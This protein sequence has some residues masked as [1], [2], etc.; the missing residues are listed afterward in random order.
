MSH[1]TFLNWSTGKDSA[2]ALYRLQQDPT[3]RVEKLLTTLN[4][5]DS[6]VSMHGIRKELLLKQVQRIGLPVSILELQKGISLPDY[7]MAL[8]NKLLAL[9]DQG[10]THSAFGDIFL[11]DLKQYREAKLATIAFKAVFP[12]WNKDSYSLMTEFLDVG[13]KAISVCVNSEVLD[14]TMVGRVID[15]EFLK[16]LPKEV[17]PCGENGE[18]HTFVYDG[19]IFNKPVDFQIGEKRLVTFGKSEE[20]E[21]M[22]WDSSF[23]YCDIYP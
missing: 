2:M 1:K 10:Y 22:D 18:F 15:K 7:E 3:Y 23:W 8:H 21:K 20:A 13:F 5:E 14:Q 9:K 17:D 19:P 11:E 12:L 16:M 4:Q 6:R